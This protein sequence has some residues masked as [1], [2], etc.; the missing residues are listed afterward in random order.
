ME[1]ALKAYEELQKANEE[2][3]QMMFRQMTH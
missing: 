3:Q 2:L 1:E